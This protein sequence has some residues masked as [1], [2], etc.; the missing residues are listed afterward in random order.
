MAEEVVLAG[1][2]GSLRRDSFNAA[3]L[4]EAQALAPAD[5]RLD[6]VDL[7]E[8]PLY[9]R[10]LENDG[11][12]AP[13]E[14]FRRALAAA[15]GLVVAT[16]E[17]NYSI[18]GVLKNAIDWASRPPDSPLDSK[19]MAIMGAGGRFGTVRAQMHLREI[20]LHNSMRVMIDPEVFV[21]GAWGAFDDQGRLTDERL[22]ERVRQLM[23]AFGEFVR[24]VPGDPTLRWA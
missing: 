12:P 20:A 8:L 17:Y 10:D 23:T 6:I 22:R 19:P 11:I 24:Y 7:A 5:V 4:R 2:A 18:P 16:P 21:A 15:D 14:D 9:N 1:I 3:L 13:V